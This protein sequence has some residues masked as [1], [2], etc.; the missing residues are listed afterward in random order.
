MHCGFTKPNVCIV[1]PWNNAGDPLHLV[2]MYISH[3]L[4]TVV[5]LRT[6]G[7][8][9]VFECIQDVPEDWELILWEYFSDE[10]HPVWLTLITPL[11]GLWVGS[12]ADIVAFITT[13][14]MYSLTI[15]KVDVNLFSLKFEFLHTELCVEMHCCYSPE[16][17]SLSH[18]WTGNKPAVFSLWQLAASVDDQEC[19]LHPIWF[20]CLTM[21]QW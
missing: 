16:I 17:K 19:M 4:C 10:C 18:T 1:P 8:V 5:I 11:D 14:D 9:F 21:L 12:L 2:S 20:M 15:A 3:L 13:C 7:S 6:V